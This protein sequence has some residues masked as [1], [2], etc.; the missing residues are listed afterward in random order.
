MP[1]VSPAL[2]SPIKDNRIVPSEW[3]I[4]EKFDGHRLIVTVG[5]NTGRSL[6]EQDR[7]GVRAWSRDAKDR[8]LPP[9]LREALR[10]L[11]EGT[12][13]GEL[14]VPG[15]RSYGVTVVE[16]AAELVY[17]VFDVL[18]LL[19]KDLTSLGMAARYV[20]RREMLERIFAD[21]PETPVT[22]AETRGISSVDEIPR[23]AKRVWDRDGEGL[24]LKRLSSIYQVGKRTKDWLKVKQQR[25]AV[26]TIVGFTGG[27]MGPH[28]IIVLRDD[29]GNETT[30][31][32][33]NLELLR[34]IEENPRSFVGRKLRIEFQERTP[35][36][37]YRHPRWDHL[38][39][40][41]E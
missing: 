13:D 36:G 40:E 41:G 3:W 34:Q 4:E 9:H 28:S 29:E 35:D 23:M 11:P 2:A 30:V 31:K 7:V 37:S 5:D 1:F 21:R 22:L 18:H 15:Q 38:V 25:S 14:L 17:V 6:F 20:D 19:G 8:I 24:I 12:Y 16:N 39:E 10:E 27:T 33:K 32:W 26:L